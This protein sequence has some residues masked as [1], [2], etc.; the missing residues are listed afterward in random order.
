MGTKQF[1]DKKTHRQQA[2]HSV[3]S[4]S[5]ITCHGMS[6]TVF[7]HCDLDLR[8]QLARLWKNAPTADRLYCL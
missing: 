1:T 5:H 6:L 7:S 2:K 8:S 4:M 3:K